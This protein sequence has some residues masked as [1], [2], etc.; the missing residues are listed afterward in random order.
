MCRPVNASGPPPCLQDYHLI[1]LLQWPWLVTQSSVWL[2][3][4]HTHTHTY[5]DLACWLL[6]QLLW[7]VCEWLFNTLRVS[8]VFREVL[9]C[10]TK[11]YCC[12][13]VLATSTICLVENT[14]LTTHWL[15]F[16]QLEARVSS[17]GC[18]FVANKYH[19]FWFSLI[20]QPGPYEVKPHFDL[21]RWW[22]T[23][24]IIKTCEKFR[25]AVLC[26]H[27]SDMNVCTNHHDNPS[28][29]QPHVSL[30]FILW[31]PWMSLAE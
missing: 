3:L 7:C 20:G 27:Q 1:V 15:I 14:N 23:C 11:Q 19:S 6:W 30:R 16:A 26:H 9:S 17:I 29:C 2:N 4:S 31:G 5:P 21:I 22:N 10:V 28:K 13:S 25:E 8:S 18:L 12:C 24:N